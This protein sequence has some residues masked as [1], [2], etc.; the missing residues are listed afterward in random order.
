MPLLLLLLLLLVLLCFTC[1]CKLL[2]SSPVAASLL[3]AA[4]AQAWHGSA[5]R[6]SSW[7]QRSQRH[8]KPKSYCSTACLFDN[9][10]GSS[11]SRSSVFY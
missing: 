1:S 6:L 3:A 8:T 10:S 2:L 4:G 11:S 5:A 9:S 7:Q